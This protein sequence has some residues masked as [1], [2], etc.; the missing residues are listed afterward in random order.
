MSLAR[1]RAQYHPAIST[2]D[3]CSI[4]CHRLCAQLGK[5][6]EVLV[7]E[8]QKSQTL[9][10]PSSCSA[11]S[12]KRPLTSLFSKRSW[13]L[14]QRGGPDSLH[15]SHCSVW[16]LPKPSPGREGATAHG[17]VPFLFPGRGRGPGGGADLPAPPR[18][19][20]PTPR[21]LKSSLPRGRR[22]ASVLGRG[23]AARSRGLKR[24]P[25]NR[26][27]AAGEATPRPLPLC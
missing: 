1:V 8:Q 2:W 17:G 12:G 18:A 23:A 9:H 13:A 15:K 10:V 25:R 14:S 20:A 16:G 22:G 24:V 21:Q 7:A 5:G 11:A 6:R 26:R 19:H 3:K 27:L 4:N